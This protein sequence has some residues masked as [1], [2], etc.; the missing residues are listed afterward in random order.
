MNNCEGCGIESPVKTGSSYELLDYCAVCGANL[1]A[2]CMAKGHCGHVPA[3]S[4]TDEA[5]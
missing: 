5:A 1:C 4:G 2:D 3:I